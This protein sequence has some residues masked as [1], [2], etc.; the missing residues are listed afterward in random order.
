MK[1]YNYIFIALGLTLLFDFAGLIVGGGILDQI[2]FSRVGG[3]IVWDFTI[4]SFR[5]SV[6][7]I[8]I[9]TGAA[10]GLIIGAITRSPPENFIIL[11]LI[12]TTLALF[13]QSFWNVLAYSITTGGFTWITFL[14]ILILGPFTIMFLFSLIEFF[15]GTD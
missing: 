15:R 2:G 4:S 1:V 13:L 8:L 7:G 14:I 12:V 10:A 3:E 5:N 11:P 6:T 9:I